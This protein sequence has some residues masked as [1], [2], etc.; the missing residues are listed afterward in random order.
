[1]VINAVSG[2]MA[3][4]RGKSKATPVEGPIPGSIPSTVPKKAPD[5]IHMMFNGLAATEKPWIKF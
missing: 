1:M 2:F 4:V 5:I 3:K